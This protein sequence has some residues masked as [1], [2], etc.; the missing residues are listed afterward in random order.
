MTMSRR[1]AIGTIAG[2]VGAAMVFRPSL[3]GA[4]VPAVRPPPVLNE[5]GKLKHQPLPY[6]PLDPDYVGNLTYQAF[7]HG[8]CMY[9]VVEGLVRALSEKVGGPYLTWPTAALEYGFA[10][11]NGWGSICGT[12]NGGAYA[13]NLISPNP[14]PLIDE[15]YG[16]FERTSLPNWVPDNAK[17]EIEGA[18]SN[19]ILC[20]VSILAW[21]K[22]SGMGA[23]TPERSDRCG[24]LAASVGRKVTE[25]L[26]A[27]AAGT[28]VA[29]FPITEEVQEC[30]SCHTEKASY[31]ENSQ[32]KMDCFA[33]HEK[34]PL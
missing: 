12:M 7:Q 23:F 34:H 15:L 25:L 3:S 26:N 19:S 11:V 2:G 14:R 17:F 27:Q 13:L 9:S 1:Q 20:H 28:F 31:L 30:R 33:C 6:E 5:K 10:G 32:S 24:Q 18:V 4:S 8:H 29:A 22:T 21:T 16:W